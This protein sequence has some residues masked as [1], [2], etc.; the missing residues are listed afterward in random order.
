MK[1]L[2]KASALVL[3]TKRAGKTLV[4]LSLLALL[5]LVG[6]G[7]SHAHSASAPTGVQIAAGTGDIHVGS[8]NP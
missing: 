6:A 8:G 4:L 7:M 5:G 2:T 1:G 3:A